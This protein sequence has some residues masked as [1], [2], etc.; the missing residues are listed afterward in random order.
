M[1]L[2]PAM[3]VGA[4]IELTEDGALEELPLQLENAKNCLSWEGLDASSSDDDGE[5]S[6]P[7]LLPP[8]RP[9]RPPAPRLLTPPFATKSLPLENI[10]VP[11]RLG[12]ASTAPGTQAFGAY[13]CQEC[14]QVFVEEWH[15]LQHSREHAREPPRPPPPRR[16]LRCPDCGKRFFHQ[17]RFTRHVK[18]HLR[19]AQAGIWLQRRRGAR[20]CS[21][22]SYVYE[23]P[24]LGESQVD[25]GGLPRPLAGWEGPTGLG[26]QQAKAHPGRRV[27]QPKGRP[28]ARTPETRRASKGLGMGG[29]RGTRRRK[30]MLGRAFHLSRAAGTSPIPPGSMED[31][32]RAT[33][34]DSKVGTS[35]PPPINGQVGGST[36]Q[37]AILDGQI[38]GSPLRT[39]VINAEEE[40]AIL[41]SLVGTS[42]LHPFRTVVVGAEEPAA[43]LEGQVGVSPLHPTPLLAEEFPP[44][45]FLEAEPGL[46]TAVDAV[47]LRLVPL[48]PDP[49]GLVPWGS[50]GGGELP[51]EVGDTQPTAFQLTGYLPPLNPQGRLPGPAKAPPTPQHPLL[52]QLAPTPAGEPPQVLELEYTLGGGLAAEPWLGSATPEDSDDFIV[53]E[54]EADTGGREEVV[55]GQL[56]PRGLERTPSPSRRQYFQCPD[57]GVRYSQALQL[58]V[59]R[60]GPGRQLCSC[61]RP[62]RGLLHL[63]RHQLWQLEGAA[64]LCAACGEALQ[65]HRA[66]GRHGGQ[67]PGAPCFRCPCGA[68]FQRLPRYLWHR[69]QNQP[70]GLGVFSL[71]SFLS[72]A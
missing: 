42:P 46:S 52:L 7:A 34:L 28:M 45:L 13:Q 56:G 39:L 60:R 26:K 5:A 69:I 29:P 6:T 58:R 38:G 48:L 40:A 32:G 9:P 61:G 2:V 16:R 49:Q 64:F 4:E 1:D 18:W 70:P 11:F 19:L 12:P 17:P 21:L 22:T 55:A 71:A 41:A 15:Y 33:V 67:H 51:D 53:V 20:P 14:C 57:C 72:P 27:G 63:L 62:F 47:T 31:E 24:G 37:A 3:E 8:L 66:L 68:G 23:P 44:S 59:H 35:P 30:A 43:I 36:L 50:Q 65:G 10:I 25:S 54:L